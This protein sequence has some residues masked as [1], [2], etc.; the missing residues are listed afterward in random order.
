[1]NPWE[2]RLVLVAII[3][4]ALSFLKGCQLDGQVREL[5]AGQDVVSN[6]A[7][8]SGIIAAQT[9][10][11]ARTVGAAIAE[12]LPAPPPEFP[13]GRRRGRGVPDDGP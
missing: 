12:R 9:E 4:S 13:V 1:M 10:S 6:F 11:A 3:V 5:Q 2:F 8:A 7:M